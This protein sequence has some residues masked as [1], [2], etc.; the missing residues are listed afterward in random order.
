VTTIDFYE[1]IRSFEQG[2]DSFLE[3][4]GLNVTMGQPQAVGR[5]AGNKAC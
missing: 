3:K 1:K 2:Q 5:N 4:I